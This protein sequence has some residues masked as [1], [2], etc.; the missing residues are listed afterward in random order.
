MVGT[1]VLEVLSL[2]SS[3]QRLGTDEL[4]TRSRTDT[5]QPIMMNS[6]LEFNKNNNES[7]KI[8]RTRIEPKSKNYI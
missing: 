6:K 3:N 2:I 8:L 7:F 5:P 4:Q 1:E